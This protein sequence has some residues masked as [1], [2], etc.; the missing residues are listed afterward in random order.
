MYETV[1]ILS[2]ALSCTIFELSDVVL[3]VLIVF[4]NCCLVL[5]CCHLA[6]VCFASTSQVIGQE[7]HF[8]LHQSSDWLEG[9]SPKWPI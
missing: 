3:R 4:F 5:L 7:G 1:R 9:S 6:I 2:M 8:L